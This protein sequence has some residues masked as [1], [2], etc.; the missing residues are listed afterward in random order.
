MGKL[1]TNKEREKKKMLRN[2]Y[3]KQNEE[4]PV[5]PGPREKDEIEKEFR[6]VFSQAAQEQYKVF[7]HSETLKQ[8]NMK[9]VQL[10]NEAKDRSDIDSKTNKEP[11]VKN[12]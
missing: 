6:E 7:V 2:F 5:V 11:E 4:L 10:S 3:K 8:L 1:K 9:L 12:D